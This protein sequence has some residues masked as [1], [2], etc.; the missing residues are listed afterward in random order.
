MIPSKKDK[1]YLQKIFEKGMTLEVSNKGGYKFKRNGSIDLEDWKK[2]TIVAVKKYI[3]AL[4]SLSSLEAKPKP[5]Q[6]TTTALTETDRQQTLIAAQNL[7]DSQNE[8][9]LHHV[10]SEE[11]IAAA[12]EYFDR[13]H[14][15]VNH[16]AAR[17]WLIKHGLYN[18]VD[19]WNI[20]FDV[21]EYAIII[22][23]D[24]MHY[25][26]YAIDKNSAF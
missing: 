6:R 22:P 7:T 3:T 24:E 25:G 10:D 16:V 1:E 26:K 13:C 19:R 17:K 2:F 20:G 23:V 14:N 5:K 15:N 4:Q 18:E 11:E 8:T 12:K 9:S 21:E